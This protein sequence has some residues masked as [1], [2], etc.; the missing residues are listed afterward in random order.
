MNKIAKISIF[1]WMMHALVGCGNNNE[2]TKT[3]IPATTADVVDVSGNYVTEGYAQKN[4]GYDWVSA[5]VKQSENGITV[6]IRSRADKKKPTCTFDA[7]AE[8]VDNN[9]YKALVNGKNILFGF[10]GDVLSIYPEKDEDA[11][12]LNYYCSG[13]ASLAGEYKKIQEA[14]DL[15]QIDTTSVR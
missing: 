7:N 3:E 15:K 8:K 11:G 14:L 1:V 2:N 10:K 5:S 13:G 4:E 9:N 6:S 12:L